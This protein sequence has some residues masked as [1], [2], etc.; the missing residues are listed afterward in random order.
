MVKQD[1]RIVFMGT[2]E[3]AVPSLKALIDEGYNVV[4]VITAPDKKAGRGKKIRMSAVKVFAQSNKLNILQPHNLKDEVFI[5]ELRDLNANLQIV[6][7]FRMLPEV[8]WLMPEFGTFNLHASLLPQYRGAAPINFA[9]INGEKSTGLTTF[10]IDKKIDTGRIIQ[11]EKIDISKT[12]NAGT[13]HDKM[14][15]IGSKLILSTVNSI[16][17]DSIAPYAQI[18][19]S[20]END[21]LKSAPKIKK[22][23]CHINWNNQSETI[24]NF[25]RGLSPYPAAFSEL[26]TNEGTEHLVKIYKVAINSS[27]EP[28]KNFGHTLSDGKT[29]LS[30]A[31][32]SGFIDILELQLSGKK[33]MNITDF[34]RG[35]QKVRDCYF[36]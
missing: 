18:S 33:Q 12:D 22:E 8:V 35:F 19:I 34:L 23:D 32:K 11:Q 3:F 1:L 36:K 27:K 5:N 25:V 15:K 2:P 28:I 21:A 20:N 7:A 13:L 14:I 17:T 24:Y 31:T 30:V 16:V 29:Y 9:I 10:F 6:I 26:I 4:G